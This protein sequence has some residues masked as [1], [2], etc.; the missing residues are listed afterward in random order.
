MEDN[1]LKN[2]HLKGII[3]RSLNIITLFY[4]YLLNSLPGQK[5]SAQ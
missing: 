2:E 1:K 5:A 4:V 3:L